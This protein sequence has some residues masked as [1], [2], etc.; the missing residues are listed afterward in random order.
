MRIKTK[1]LNFTRLN[2]GNTL[3][4]GE[5]NGQLSMEVAQVFW[6]ILDVS[7]GGNLLSYKTVKDLKEKIAFFKFVAKGKIVI[8][9]DAD[10]TEFI[11]LEENDF[12]ACATYRSTLIH[13]EGIDHK[14][15]AIG[16]NQTPEGKEAL[17]DI[18]KNDIKYFDLFYWVEASGAIEHLFKKFNGYPIPNV[19]AKE[20][21]NTNK[22][23]ILCDDEVHFKRKIGGS[24]ELFE[25]MIFG[26]R[27]KILLDKIKTNFE[28]YEDFRK[29]INE[30]VTT[31]ED[32]RYLVESAFDVISYF[33]TANEEEGLEDLFQEWYDII[34]QSISIL[35]NY[36]YYYGENIN[37]IN[38][39]IHRGKLLLKE[40][41]VIKVHR[42]KI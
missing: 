24:E 36:K 1:N 14:L 15:T 31:L 28:G 40:M 35:D 27:D 7:Y 37:T 12:L 23:I 19:F 6:D 21:L 42:F 29:R 39:A 33:I 38:W 8:K 11:E 9:I 30:S 20:F 2:S 5:S 10:N 22:N 17:C 26:F 3:L 25:K 34:S 18:I 32:I 4:Y 13:K 41:P 16:C